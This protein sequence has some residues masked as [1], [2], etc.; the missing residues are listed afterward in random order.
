MICDRKVWTLFGPSTTDSCQKT[1]RRYGVCVVVINNDPTVYCNIDWFHLV[2]SFYANIFYPFCKQHG[3]ETTLFSRQ[4]WGVELSNKRAPISA[5][6]NVWLPVRWRN[7]C[8]GVHSLPLWQKRQ[9][10]PLLQPSYKFLPTFSVT[11]PI[12]VNRPYHLGGY[13]IPKMSL[14]LCF[15]FILQPC[16]R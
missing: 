11:I 1:T 10:D 4:N 2:C 6:G 13:I 3:L 14:F 7:G 9:Y 5:K 8:E 16:L 12:Y 15:S